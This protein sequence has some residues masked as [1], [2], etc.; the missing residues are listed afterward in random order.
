[1]KSAKRRR[2][3][4]SKNNLATFIAEPGKQELVITQEFDAPRALVFRAFTD[5]EL[6][7]QWQGPYELTTMLEEFEPKSGGSWRFVQQDKGGNTYRFHGVFHEVSSPERIIQTFE[8]EGLP[9]TGH[10]ILDS[11]RFE[12]LPGKRTRVISNSVFLSVAD[13][14]GMVQ[15]GMESGMNDSYE[16]LAAMLASLSG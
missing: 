15:S 4:M 12:E 16:R 1:M 10:V 2:F 13:R 8:Y 9:E 7:V 3:T 11:T 5:P 14:D 6:F